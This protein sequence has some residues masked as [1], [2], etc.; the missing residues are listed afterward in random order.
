[1]FYNTMKFR[2]QYHTSEISHSTL[3]P[4]VLWKLMLVYTGHIL[5]NCNFE[6]LNFMPPMLVYIGC[7]PHC[8]IFAARNALI[9]SIF[10][11]CQFVLL[12][13][14]LLYLCSLQS[15]NFINMSLTSVCI[16]IRRTTADCKDLHF[17][18][19]I[20]L[21]PGITLSCHSCGMEDSIGKEVFFPKTPRLAQEPTQ[22]PTQWA[23]VFFFPGYDIH[24]SPPPKVKNEQNCLLPCILSG[25]QRGCSILLAWQ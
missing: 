17:L 14:T 23:L 4:W 22:P 7:V 2:I 1:M 20:S 16:V 21:T 19:I 13:A 9:L 24:L 10:H 18:N 15:L 5:H 12:C 6:S 25:M 11:L 3:L 8:C